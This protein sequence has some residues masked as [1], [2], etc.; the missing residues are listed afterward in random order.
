M[1]ARPANNHE[2]DEGTETHERG[3]HRTRKPKAEQWSRSIALVQYQT[4][5]LGAQHLGTT[6][7]FY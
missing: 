5:A 1:N 4:R 3:D 7:I 2:R 6:K